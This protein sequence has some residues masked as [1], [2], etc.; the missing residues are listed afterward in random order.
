M[1]R[2]PFTR[3]IIGEAGCKPG[4][5]IANARGVPGTVGFLALTRHDRRV[6]IV[7]SHH[8]LFGSGAREKDAVWLI[9]EMT[10]PI[11]QTGYG[12]VG[13]V[14]FDATEV[15]VDCA[16]ALL[17]DDVTASRVV[18]AETK[19]SVATVL[20]LGAK[21]HKTGAATGRTEGIVIDT[22]YTERAFVDGVA[23]AARGQIQV[24]SRTSGGFST[25]GDSGAALRNEGGELVGLLWG[26]TPRGDSVVCP[27]APVLYVLNASPISLL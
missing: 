5:C 22:D 16:V 26:V 23:Q 21:V 1:P 24:R 2:F 27:I 18:K 4:A 9:G 8:V 19:T 7:T 13:S 25:D 6:V 3:E 12:R 10:T 15:F 14:R 17:D 20:A 11:G